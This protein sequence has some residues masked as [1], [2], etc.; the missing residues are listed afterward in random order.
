MIRVH[1]WWLDLP[2]IGTTLAGLAV[3]A[4]RSDRPAEAARCW[5]A[6]M[7]F[8][9]RQDFAVLAHGRL[10]PLLVDALGEARV[11]DAETASAGWDR[12]EAVARARTLLEDLRYAFR[13]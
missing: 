7:R 6:A 10:R 3:A 1:P 5:G 4:A 12:T 9:T 11:A 13:M 2:V 8:G